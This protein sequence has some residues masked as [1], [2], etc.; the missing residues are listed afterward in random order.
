MRDVFPL[1]APDGECRQGGGRGGPALESSN[2][3]GRHSQ[4]TFEFR[5]EGS[6]HLIA[7]CVTT[8]AKFPS[9]S[10]N[11][12]CHPPF[13]GRPHSDGHFHSTPNESGGLVGVAVTL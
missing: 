9:I 2:R 7:G 1:P 12:I 6:D 4:R 11:P 13:G 10:A 5:D 8:A 3:T